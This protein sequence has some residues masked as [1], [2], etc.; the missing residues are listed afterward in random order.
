MSDFDDSCLPSLKEVIK[1]YGL[2]ADKALGQNYLIDQNILQKIVVSADISQDDCVLE[3]GPGPGALT[4]ALLKSSAK[5][6]FVI[7]KDKRFLPVLDML[8]NHVGER[9]E[10]I[11]GDALKIPLKSLGASKIKIVANLPYNIGTQLVLNWLDELAYVSSMILMLQKEVVDRLRALPN[12]KAYGRLS[13][14]VQW[15]CLVR[16]CFDVPPTAFLPAPKVTSSIVE[17]NPR[18]TPL[19]PCD[20]MVLQAVTHAGFHQRRK[21]IRTSLK[22][23]SPDILDILESLNIKGTLRAENLSIED[24][25]AIARLS[26]NILKE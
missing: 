7:E 25:C 6:I 3:I 15:A 26:G 19:A 2:V 4:R 1:T 10:I 20:K 11:H 5:K 21:M 12:T 22:G 16:R 14:L 23:L 8:K 9:L 17:L 24:F 18:N 13:I